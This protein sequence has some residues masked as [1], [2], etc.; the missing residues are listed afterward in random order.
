MA[1]ILQLI[2][3]ALPTISL[4]AHNPVST[5]SGHHSLGEVLE[6][7]LALLKQTHG[8]PSLKSQLSDTIRSCVRCMSVSEFVTA[9]LGMLD[10][11]NDT[12]STKPHRDFSNTSKLHLKIQEDA[13]EVVQERLPHI[14]PS[15]RA[16]LSEPFL[17]IASYCTGILRRGSLSQLL[18]ALAVLQKLVSTTISDE[19][20]TLTEIVPTLLETL[21][22]SLNEEAVLVQGF[23]LMESLMWVIDIAVP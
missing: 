15:W 3:Q 1:V 13:L 11:K 6:L 17:K 18:P 8:E 2:Q 22:K 4:N 21:V 16:Q 12:V 10:S 7:L 9:I 14:S 20:I 5:E 19:L 23:T